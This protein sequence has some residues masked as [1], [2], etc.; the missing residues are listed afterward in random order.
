ML[1]N[2]A[3]KAEGR[4]RESLKLVLV[5]DIIGSWREWDYR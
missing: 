2:A 5:R 1:Y 4:E 3:S